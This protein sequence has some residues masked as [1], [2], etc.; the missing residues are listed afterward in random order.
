MSKRW[1][2]VADFL[3]GKKTTVKQQQQQQNIMNQIKLE[4]TKVKDDKTS[5]KKRNIHTHIR[6]SKIT[7]KNKTRQ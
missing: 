5:Q 7:K 6:H 4:Q 3:I 2:I 1:N